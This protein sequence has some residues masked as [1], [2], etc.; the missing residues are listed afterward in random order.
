MFCFFWGGEGGAIPLKNANIKNQALWPSLFCWDVSKY[1]I[2]WKSIERFLR[3][4]WQTDRRTKRQKKK[5]DFTGPFVFNREPITIFNVFQ[6]FMIIYWLSIYVKCILYIIYTYIHLSI[7]KCVCVYSILYNISMSSPICI[8]WFKDA[9]KLKMSAICILW[10]EDACN[11][12]IYIYIGTQGGISLYI[13]K[14]RNSARI[15][16]PRCKFKVYLKKY[17]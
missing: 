15:C 4:L 5:A 8:L 9:C 13:Y 1:E 7:N 16:G 6:I 14:K 2:L 17:L 11:E 3:I 12:E 10:F